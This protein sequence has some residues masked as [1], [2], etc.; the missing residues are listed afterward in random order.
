M[1]WY[2]N[3]RGWMS[4]WLGVA[5]LLTGLGLSAQVLPGQGVQ[6]RI[7]LP[8]HDRTGSGR[9]RSLLM[10]D[11]MVPRGPGRMLVRGVRL[12]TYA[13]DGDRRIVDLIVEAPECFFDLRTRVVSSSGPMKATRADGTMRLEGVGFEWQQLTS[14]LVV[15]HNVRTV[16]K[17]RLSLERKDKK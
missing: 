15:H 4:R 5:L 10:G 3:Y 11:S 8:D 9:L 17:Q 12:E 14:R 6:K 1:D 13:Y 7:K 2:E 16:L